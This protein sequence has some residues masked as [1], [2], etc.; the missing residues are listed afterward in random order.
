LSAGAS[1]AALTT[2]IEN[3]SKATEELDKRF[4][5]ITEQLRRWAGPDIG[6]QAIFGKPAVAFDDIQKGL[7][8]QNQ[9]AKDLVTS[10][11]KENDIKQLALSGDK[12]AVEL[13][14]SKLK[15]ERERIELLSKARDNPALTGAVSGLIGQLEREKAIRDTIVNQAQAEA[16]AEAET[17]RAAAVAT[18]LQSVGSGD[19]IQKLE[20]Q[21]TIE[22]QIQQ[23]RE[24]VQDLADSAKKGVALGPNAQAIVDQA[25][26]EGVVDDPNKPVGPIPGGRTAGV[27]ESQDLV[28]QIEKNK[29][30]FDAFNPLIDEASKQMQGLNAD[31]ALSPDDIKRM[32]GGDE[33]GTTVDANRELEQSASEAAT[34]LSQLSNLDFTGIMSLNGLVISIQ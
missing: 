21:R 19:F 26:K 17:A 14:E 28:N 31:S 34:S 13:A 8:R 20:K 29:Q 30:S 25:I 27:G 24:Q 23:A 10:T 15:F 1:A 7:E 32:E 16:D 5:N 33:S 11:T 4:N 12:T 9:L 18:F 22:G 6:L 2:D 3:A